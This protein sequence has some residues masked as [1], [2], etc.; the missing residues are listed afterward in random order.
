MMP[1]WLPCGLDVC[2][3]MGQR[4]HDPE[5]SRG[6]WGPSHGELKGGTCTDCDTR[7]RE[8][9]RHAPR[10]TLCS[11][12]TVL[13]SPALDTTLHL[14]GMGV[15][16]PCAVEVA[17]RLTFLPL[18]KTVLSAA[19][20]LL[21]GVGVTQPCAGEAEG[22]QGLCVILCDDAYYRH[23]WIGLSKGRRKMMRGWEKHRL[24]KTCT[25]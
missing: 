5:T 18:E 21:L 17:L 11:T 3:G 25:F 22:E 16:Q 20:H 24:A 12:M 1:M 10:S 8:I 7:S 15:T 9:P 14:L 6:S 2:R 13:S 4:S 23:T 19:I